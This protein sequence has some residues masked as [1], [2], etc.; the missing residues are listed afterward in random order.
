MRVRRLWQAALAG[1][2]AVPLA[3]PAVTSPAAGLPTTI[4][5]APVANISGQTPLPATATPIWQTNGTVWAMAYSGGKLYIGGNFTKARP[6]GVAPG[7]TGEVTVKNL[8]AI[9]TVT[10]NYISTFK[11][12]A[13]KIVYGLSVSP[14]G[15]TL[16]A[17]GDF[18]TVDGLVRNQVASFDLTKSPA[19][20]TSFAPV[21]SGQRVRAVSATN[22]AVYLA[23]AFTTA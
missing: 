23:G 11:H 22:S 9:D 14:D 13:N 10:G 15:H 20:L 16:Y 17:G 3:L 1:A 12:T 7:G 2:L 4:D 5:A 18:T 8:L 19:P 6:P 21:M